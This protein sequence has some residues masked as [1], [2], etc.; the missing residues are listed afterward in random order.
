YMFDEPLDTLFD[1]LPESALTW[2]VEPGRIIAQAHRFADR[3]GEEA[4][5][6]QSRHAYFPPPDS[7]FLD[8]DD[9][10]RRLAEQV[11][12]DVGSVVTL[13]TPQAGYAVPIEVK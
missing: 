6:N 1:F 13:R 5:Q 3:I 8:A 12:V 11:T 4:E 9:L 10:Q 7:L 2:L